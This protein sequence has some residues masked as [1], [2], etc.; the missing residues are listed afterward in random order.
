M[1]MKG[2]VKMVSFHGLANLSLERRKEFEKKIVR[3][4]D[5]CDGKDGVCFFVG[6]GRERETRKRKIIYATV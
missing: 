1:K 5:L 6:Y 2:M 3:R 4:D